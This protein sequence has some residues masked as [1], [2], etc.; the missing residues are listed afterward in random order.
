[1][2]T[3]ASRT[4]H[5]LHLQSGICAI[6]IYLLLLFTF[7]KLYCHDFFFVAANIFLFYYA[8]SR[9]L[10]VFAYIGTKEIVRRQ[11]QRAQRRR[12]MSLITR[13]SETGLY[14]SRDCVIYNLM[15]IRARPRFED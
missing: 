9:T 1:M 8:E 6:S 11:S 15:L 4:S 3:R 14:R 10:I 13:S 12:S 7:K 2:T 5:E